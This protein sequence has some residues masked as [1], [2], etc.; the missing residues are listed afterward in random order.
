MPTTAQ[1]PLLAPLAHEHFCMPRP[2]A[3]EPRVEGFIS[4]EDD[5][6]GKSRPAA[7]VTRCVECGAAHYEPM[8]ES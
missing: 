8:K 7:F 1:K 6:A 2:S 3:E 4:Y 5:A